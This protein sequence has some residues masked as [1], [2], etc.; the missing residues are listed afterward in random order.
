M[1]KDPEHPLLLGKGLALRQFIV[2]HSLNGANLGRNGLTGAGYDSERE[3]RPSYH[4]MLQAGELKDGIACDNWVG[5]L[6]EGEVLTRVVASRPEKTAYRVRL[7]GGKV[8]EEA[9]QAEFLGKKP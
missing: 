9:L 2:L 5:L 7:A 4:K 1:V 3:R 8:V 6:Y